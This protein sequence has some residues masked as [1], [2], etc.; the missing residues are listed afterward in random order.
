MS[1]HGQPLRLFSL[2]WLIGLAMWAYILYATLTPHP[3]DMPGR[4]SD[5][6]LHFTGY[7]VVTAWFAQLYQ[8]GA[9]RQRQLVIFALLAVALEFAQLL[10]NTRSFEWAD[11]LANSAGVL[12]AGLL[13][14]GRL[15]KILLAG[16]R[17]IL[18]R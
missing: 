10:V 2:W 12:V 7:F 17:L 8:S 16:E 15:E 9:A 14:R 6:V 3:M 18:R 13:I 5:K 1:A 4:Y 11:M